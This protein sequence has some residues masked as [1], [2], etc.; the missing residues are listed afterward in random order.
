MLRVLVR[1]PGEWTLPEIDSALARLK[2]EGNLLEAIGARS[3]LAFVADR[4][5]GS[6]RAVLRRLQRESD[7]AQDFEIN[8]GDVEPPSRPA[9]STTPEGSRAESTET[10]TVLGHGTKVRD[11]R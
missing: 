5:V 7:Y 6:E 8:A 9:P 11:D 3:D 2:R 10:G 4:A 1:T